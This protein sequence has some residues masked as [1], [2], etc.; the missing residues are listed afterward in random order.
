MDLE[1][2][3]EMNMHSFINKTQWVKHTTHTVSHESSES[4]VGRKVKRYL[5]VFFF[6]MRLS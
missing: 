3:S 4:R 1:P 6:S 2:F 5:I